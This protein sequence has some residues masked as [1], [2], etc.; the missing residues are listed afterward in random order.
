MD[1]A[2]ALGGRL[3]RWIAPLTPRHERALTHLQMAF[4]D[5]GD[6]ERRADRAAMWDNLGR[7]FAETFVLDRLAADPSRLIIGETW[8]RE[9]TAASGRG[10]SSRCT[11]PIG[12]CPPRP[13]SGS[14]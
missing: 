11:W 13:W 8:R 9:P 7:V 10:G 1:A 2:S 4:P 5:M 6:A 12:N 3:W 14:A